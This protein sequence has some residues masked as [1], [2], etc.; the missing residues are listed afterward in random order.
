MAMTEFWESRLHFMDLRMLF[1]PLGRD[2]M[3][4][5]AWDVDLGL[6]AIV[7]C[8]GPEAN[9]SYVQMR[10]KKNFPSGRV[11]IWEFAF[12][13][14]TRA[15]N[16]PTDRTMAHADKAVS[17]ETYLRRLVAAELPHGTMISEPALSSLN[18]IILTLADRLTTVASGFTVDA[19]KETLP[20]SH[21]RAAV[22][23][24]VPPA[25]SQECI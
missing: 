22:R 20:A 8:G 24:T 25:L 2:R 9:P 7:A 13:I 1:S 18:S 23:M 17:Q 14:R 4:P 5:T 11:L 19:N 6:L 12:G 10:F 21:V 15:A 3:S 16:A